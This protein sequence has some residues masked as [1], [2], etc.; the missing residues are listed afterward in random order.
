MPYDAENIA[1][2]LADLDSQSE[3]MREIRKNGVVQS[4]L[5]HDWV[6]RWRAI[7]D[8]VGLEP[9]PALIARE[10][11]LKKLAGDVERGKQ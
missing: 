8:M 9:R 5:R 4:L 2:V 1:E 3:R 7:L 10:E 6:Y 11:R